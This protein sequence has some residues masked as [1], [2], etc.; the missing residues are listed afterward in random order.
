MTTETTPRGLD[1]TD[2]QWLDQTYV[3]VQRICASHCGRWRIYSPDLAHD[4]FLDVVEAARRN[5]IRQ[6]EALA[7]FISIIAKRK[8][9]HERETH[10][11]TA[12]PVESPQPPHFRHDLETQQH[13]ELLQAAIA[14]LRPL[15][16]ELLTRFYLYEHTQEQICHD[17]HLT[18]NQYRLGKS[19]AKARLLAVC[20]RRLQPPNPLRR[21]PT[22]ATTIPLTNAATA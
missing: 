10:R 12:D 6:P 7:G 4:T 2:P 17:L 1:P 20:Q 15:D 16:R 19:R 21:L 13:R 5:M 18:D 9:W 3:M 11:R 14:R 22:R 8:M